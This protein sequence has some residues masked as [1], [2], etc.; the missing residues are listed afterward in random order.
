M[1]KRSG[2]RSSAFITA[3]NFVLSSPAGTGAVM[4]GL[5]EVA[6][7]RD[8][9]ILDEREKEHAVNPREQPVQIPSAAE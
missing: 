7:G 4:S 2:S 3:L 9:L 8:Q 1:Q 5:R 6:T